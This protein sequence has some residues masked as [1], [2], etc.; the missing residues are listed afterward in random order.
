MHATRKERTGRTAD[1]GSRRR[2]VCIQRGDL[3]QNRR[4][5]RLDQRLE[6][7]GKRKKPRKRYEGADTRD[8]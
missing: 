4:A 7:W 8:L 5:R 6:K 2:R 3:L 1:E